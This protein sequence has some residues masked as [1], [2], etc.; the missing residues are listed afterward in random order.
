[1]QCNIHTMQYQYHILPTPP[2]PCSWEGPSWSLQKPDRSCSV[3]LI[4][5]LRSF[6]EGARAPHVRCSGDRC[7]CTEAWQLCNVTGATYT[8]GQTAGCR[9]R[10]RVAIRRNP[11]VCLHVCLHSPSTKG[12]TNGL[13]QRHATASPLPHAEFRGLQ[14]NGQANSAGHAGLDQHLHVPARAKRTANGSITCPVNG[15]QDGPTCLQPTA[16]KQPLGWA[17]APPRGPS[18][19]VP[20]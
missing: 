18:H 16:D 3:P 11:N 7:E 10:W 12:E 17:A 14:S 13:V 4:H 15:L 5:P 1:M 8:S 9:E 20:P 6:Q 2:M 19:H